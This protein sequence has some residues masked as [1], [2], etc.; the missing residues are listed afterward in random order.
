MDNGKRFIEETFPVKE[1]SLIS[2]KEKNIRQGHISTLHIWWARRPLAS[3]RATNYAALIPA[4]NNID[5]WDKKRQ[6]IIEF[7]KWENSLNRTMIRQARE[8]ILKANGNNPPKVLDCFAGGGA[9]PLEALRLGCETYACDYNPVAALILK[10]T[11]EYPQKYGN[12]KKIRA[13]DRIE[14]EKT[15]NPLLEDV[16]TWGNRILQEAK[17][18][19]GRFYP[20]EEDGSL[21]VGYIWVRTLPCQNP[22]CRAEVPLVRQYWLSNRSNKKVALHPYIEDGKCKFE[23]VGTGYKPML[24]GF[25]PS[26][27]TISRSV[28]TCL[29]CGSVI[30]D[31][32]TRKLF[33]EGKSKQKMVAVILHKPGDN[34]KKYRIANEYDTQGFLEAQEYLQKKRD[35][36]LLELGIEPIPDEPIPSTMP[37]GIHTSTYGMN[38]W[39]SLFN[40]RQKLALITFVDKVRG[41]NQKMLDEGYDEEYRRAIISYLALGVDRLAD[42]NSTLCLWHSTKELVAHTFGRQSLSM[43]WD[44][45]EVNP[46]SDATGNWNDSFIYLLKVLG[47]AGKIESAPAIVDQSSATSLP[48]PNDFFNAVFTDPPYYYNVTYSDLSDFFYVWLKRTVGDL[49]PELFSTPLSPKS[50]E[51]IQGAFWDTERYNHKDKLWFEKMLTKS[52]REINRV[53]R[54]KGI[55]TIVYTH[56]STS[57]WESLINSLLDSGLVVTGA[58]PIHTEMRERL[59]A[60]ESA[61]LASSIYI[62]ARKLDREATGFYNEV[63]EHLHKHLDKRLDRLWAE[64]I[65][66]ADFFVSA[67]GSAIEVFGK[68]EKVIDYEGNVVRADRLL[69]DIRK[70]ATDYAVRQ[71]LHNGFSEEIS[72]LTRFYV[73]YRW[74]YGEAKV[75][76]DEAHR[77]ALSCSIDLSKEW[78]RPG[79]IRKDKE[80]V[81]VLGPQ[82][83]KLEE[84]RNSAE[85]IDVLHGALLL[86]EKSKRGEM[87]KLLHKFDHGKSDSF[88]RVAQAISETLPIESKEKK[89][90]DGFLSGK[91]R[92]MEDIKKQYAEQGRLL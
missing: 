29:V 26:D 86:W 81:R 64:G 50:N 61:A 69:D 3:S 90:L 4:T 53:L 7:S 66:G 76:F 35:S 2:A 39:G 31:K 24:S 25:D 14:G 62:V 73:L 92:V 34:G 48:Y 79:F 16:K 60:K 28:A 42:Y 32:T 38:T 68:Y 74:N 13:D 67:I 58:W 33:Q 72:D 70:I 51:I 56:T 10:C 63:K 9:I 65:G 88:Y 47:H 82:D 41:S 11:L 21:A 49:Y 30:D 27:G 46:F 6:F 37:G 71:I 19:I 20:E 36:L 77:L 59:M 52:F 8:D 43:A 18:E 75:L 17:K 45:T 55:A 87:V 12:P 44:F 83:R 78:N 23:I 57:G 54:P 80:F 15:I 22:A 84:I 1:V 91:E 5:E 40:S 89:L 85:L